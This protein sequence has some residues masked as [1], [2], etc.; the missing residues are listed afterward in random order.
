MKFNEDSRVKI[1]SIMHLTRLGYKYISLKTAKW[2]LET[3]IFTDIFEES[4]KRINPEIT[5]D[6]INRLYKELVNLLDYDDNG[7]AFYER[8]TQKSGLK[9]IDFK[10][11]KS[12]IKNNSF[13]VVTELTCKNGDEEFRPDI[14]LLINGIP[15][16]FIEVKK[17]NNKS[18]IIA[19]RER[20]HTRFANPKFKKFMNITQI[21]V[22]SNN[23][24]Y[25]DESLESIQGAF[26]STATP[27][28]Q[29]NYFREEEKINLAKVLD[30]E[31]GEIENFILKDNNLSVIKNNGEYITNKNPNSPT[32][33]LC[34]SLFLKERLYFM[35]KYSIAYVKDGNKPKEKHIMR[36]PQIFATKE[37]EK[38]LNEGIKKGIIWHT[39]GSGKTALAFYNVKHLTDYYQ[40][41][42]IIPKFYFV[43][44]RLDLALQAQREFLA[45]DL[46]V[47][48]I[49]SKEEFSRL[50]K[51]NTVIHNDSGK[52]EITVVN[53]HK[54]QDDPEIPKTDDYD[55]GVQ[56]I[57]FLDEVHR[58]YNPT[59][60]FLANLQLA[61]KKSIKI[62]LTG[63]PLIS[64]DYKSKDV[65]GDYIHKYYYNLSIKDG[66]TLKLI[67]EAIE[68]K[69]KTMLENALNEIQVLEGSIKREDIFAHN[70]FVE[71]L[72]NYILEDFDNSRVMFGDNTIGAMVVCDSSK[73][74]KKLFE[75]FNEKMQDKVDKKTAS[76]ILHDIGTKEERKDQ[77]E[78]FKD[79]KID[80]LFVYNMLLTG[81]DA[82]RLKKLY[83]GRLVKSHNLLQTLTRV[84][85]RYKNFK[86]GYVVDFADIKTEF[87]ATNKA[88]FEEL[89]AEYGDEMEHYS[90]I[91]KSYEEITAD[92]K[93]IDLALFN[94]DTSNAEIFSQQINQIDDIKK[95]QEL[96]KVLDNAKTLYNMIRLLGYT[97]LIEK[98][99]FNKLRLLYNEVSNHL[100]LLNQKQ[101][102]EN[103]VD[104]E[105]I[106][107]MALENIIF[108]FVKV[109]ESELK[110]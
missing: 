12:F 4:L 110:I 65:F 31:N 6:E 47:K 49:S 20:I 1:P 73:Q 93:N 62:G 98:I 14:T 15:L 86:Y 56:R 44:D 69:Y 57:F 103:N 107:N 33:R 18:G 105:S 104:N 96:K 90:S 48:V 38:K 99:D 70:I 76:L 91:F 89:K 87:D 60:S 5:D 85:R 79:G 109:S 74:A 30:N 81:F 97:D 83:L 10:D 29:F 19:E 7:K 41:Q 64:K 54:F 108:K 92:I 72:L 63:T 51:S 13:N 22:F 16:V 21:M 52:P 61:D 59:G 32:N 36:Y 8:L 39:Q 25:D 95:I 82:P 94:Y 84:N 77:I 67:R 42:G 75:L 43:V 11:E 80:F 46:I 37:I 53:I 106:I 58:S 23:M 50:I 28:P 71:H 55:L 100:D 101:V 102:I 3:N 17:P 27:K 9:L 45:R 88:Y 2:D 26:Y 66:Y 68:T 35:L 34:T 40:S 78:A 24:E